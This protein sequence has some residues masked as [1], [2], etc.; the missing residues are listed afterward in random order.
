[1]STWTKENNLFN[2]YQIFSYPI[3]RMKFFYTK[4]SWSLSIANT[5]DYK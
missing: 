2:N 1:M 4:P 3:L 5:I